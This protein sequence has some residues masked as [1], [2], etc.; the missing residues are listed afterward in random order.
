MSDEKF[1]SFITNLIV[2]KNL[3]QQ[4]KYKR[5]GTSGLGKSFELTSCLSG[6]E[7]NE[8][9]ELS[10]KKSEKWIKQSQVDPVFSKRT[11]AVTANPQVKGYV[12]SYY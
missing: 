11:K 3:Q 1:T 4:K 12:Q 8:D 2:V 10:F 9:K 5:K 7:R 6:K